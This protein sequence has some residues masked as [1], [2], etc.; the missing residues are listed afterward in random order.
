M[1]KQEL[2]K[3]QTFFVNLFMA[4]FKPIMYLIFKFD[5]GLS[6]SFKER[7]KAVKDLNDT[8]ERLGKER[9]GTALDH[10]K[11]MKDVLK[12]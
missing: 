9:K 1:E 8:W 12:L 11:I 7:D 5:P 6:K 2:N 3:T 4:I 10:D